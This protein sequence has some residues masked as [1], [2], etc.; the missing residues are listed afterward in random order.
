MQTFTKIQILTRSSLLSITYF[1]NFKY[2]LIWRYIFKERDIK[3]FKV[4]DVLE[5]AW[6]CSEEISLGNN[7]TEILIV[8][9][10]CIDYLQ[11][12]ENNPFKT[13]HKYMDDIRWT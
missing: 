1:G 12:E 11:N 5:L 3:L 6:F 4:C 10:N 8:F 9:N 2:C 13:I 7:T